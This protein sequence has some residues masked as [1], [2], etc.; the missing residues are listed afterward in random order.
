MSENRQRAQST[1][2]TTSCARLAWAV[3]RDVTSL[4]V[5]GQG[6]R[7]P[8]RP[9]TPVVYGGRGRTAAGVDVHIMCYTLGVKSNGHALLHTL[10]DTPVR[11]L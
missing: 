3:K 4:A 7:P 8:R 10:Q 11:L 6:G 9:V 1:T 5:D 2:T